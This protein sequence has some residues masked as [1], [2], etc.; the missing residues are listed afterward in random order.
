MPLFG[1]HLAPRQVALLLALACAGALG[2]GLTAQFGFGLQ[3]CILCLTQRVPYVVAG[4]LALTALVTRHAGVRLWLLWGCALAFAINAGIAVYHV[5]VEQHWWVSTCSAAAGA[6]LA[7]S[8]EALMAALTKPAPLPPCD[9]APWRLFGI[10]F[11]GY[12]IAASLG[13]AG[14]TAWA[15]RRSRSE[16]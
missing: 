15:L 12:N 16:S 2:V 4:L 8:P 6:A 14:L 10:S 9:Q 13:L 7:D 1:L 11:A 5:G 3:P